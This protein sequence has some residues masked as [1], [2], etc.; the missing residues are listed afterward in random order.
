MDLELGPGVLEL[1][2]GADAGPQT[3]PDP[4]GCRQ[5]SPRTWPR[6]TAVA[7]PTRLYG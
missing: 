1:G 2:L 7:I 4:P 6:T 5:N 3:D